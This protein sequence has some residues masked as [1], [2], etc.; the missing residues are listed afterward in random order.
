MQAE[1][2]SLVLPWAF[3]AVC[4]AAAQVLLEQRKKTSLKKSDSVPAPK[5][6]TKP[7]STSQMPTAWR[8]DAIAS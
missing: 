4:A 7:H 5:M 6:L 8:K 3:F 1:I 2:I